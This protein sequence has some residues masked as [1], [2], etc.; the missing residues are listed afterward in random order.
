MEC[1][2]VVVENEGKE[3][4]RDAD[5]PKYVADYKGP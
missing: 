3:R 2:A 1:Q 5:S 4:E